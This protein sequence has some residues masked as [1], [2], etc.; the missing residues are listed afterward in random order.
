MGHITSLYCGLWGVP[1]C[2]FF[3]LTDTVRL[4]LGT[5]ALLCLALWASGFVHKRR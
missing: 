4:V 3:T 2:Q 5:F 1:G